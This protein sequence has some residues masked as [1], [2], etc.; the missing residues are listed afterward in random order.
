MLPGHLTWNK[1]GPTR[2]CSLS[3]SVSASTQSSSHTPQQSTSNTRTAVWWITWK[4]R[5]WKGLPNHPARLFSANWSPN[6]VDTPHRLGTVW[7]KSLGTR[8][9]H[10][11]RLSSLPRSGSLLRLMRSRPFLL[12][13]DSIKIITTLILFILIHYFRNFNH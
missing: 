2:F 3:A 9:L 6:I 1:S 8:T 13:I 11:G 5:S 10:C 7:A 12:L 4:E